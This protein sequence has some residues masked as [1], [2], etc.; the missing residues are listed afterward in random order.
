MR[1]AA[2]VVSNPQFIRQSGILKE[3]RI[4]GGLVTPRIKISI[5]GVIGVIGPAVGVAAAGCRKDAGLRRLL[6]ENQKQVPK[7]GKMTSSS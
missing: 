1:G 3:Y 6:P 2:L 4:I 7:V 5:I